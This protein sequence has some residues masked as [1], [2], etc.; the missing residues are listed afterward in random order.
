MGSRAT[1]I[2]T[3]IP[4]AEVQVGDMEVDDRTEADTL[5]GGSTRLQSE[6]IETALVPVNSELAALR[7]QLN[8]QGRQTSKDEIVFEGTAVRPKENETERQTLQR[9]VKTYWGLDLKG[10]EGNHVD[11][12]KQVHW[13]PCK[14]PEKRRLLAKFLN[15]YN[16]SNFHKILHTRPELSTSGET[17]YRRL[18]Q[19]TKNDRRLSFISRQMRGAKE[20]SRFDFD[21]VSGRLKVTFPDGTRQTFSEASDLLARCSPHLVNKIAQL[22]KEWKRCKTPGRKPGR[23]PPGPLSRK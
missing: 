8:D 21:S 18:H 4:S 9:V 17:L 15:L 10:F 13:L 16:G 2:R 11:E 22:D 1:P 7:R 20:I 6:A 12:I 14:N 3:D 5:P 23:R 19:Q